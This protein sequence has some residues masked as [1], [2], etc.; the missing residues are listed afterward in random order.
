[1]ELCSNECE[2]GDCLQYI[3][4]KTW[5][6]WDLNYLCTEYGLEENCMLEAYRP[7]QQQYEDGGGW[8]PT[9]CGSQYSLLSECYPT[10][11]TPG[12]VSNL[13]NYGYNYTFSEKGNYRIYVKS[14]DLYSIYYNYFK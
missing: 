6:D 11:N 7:P 10:A 13:L 8:L 14:Y 9:Y 2:Y 1:M 3:D 4:H 12:S 5:Q